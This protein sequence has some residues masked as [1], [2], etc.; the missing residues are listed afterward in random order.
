[1]NTFKKIF[2]NRNIICQIKVL[3]NRNDIHEMKLWRIVIGIYLGPKYQQ[4]D[5]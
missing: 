1:M 3:A 5:L 4:I 2:V